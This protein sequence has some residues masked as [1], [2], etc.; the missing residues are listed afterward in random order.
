[1]KNLCHKIL[2]IEDDAADAGLICDM[3]E[4]KEAECV[5]ATTAR[6]SSAIEMLRKNPFEVVLLDL[7]LPD[8]RGIETLRRLLEE[9]PPLPIVVLTVTAD[10][11]LAAE[12]MSMGAQD[13]LVKGRFDADQLYR[14][15]IY[16]MERSGYEQR[17]RESEEK[18]R[19][20]VENANSVVIQTDRKGTV[21]FF[22]EYGR[23]L[24]GYS[25]DEI[26]GR[27][28]RMLIPQTETGSGRDLEEMIG[29]ILNNPDGFIENVNE[30]VRKDG[31]RIWVSWRNR[32]VR[33]A[34][35]DV[36]GNLAIGQDVTERRRLEESLDI[37]SRTLE[38]LNTALKVLLEQR[39][40][41]KRGLEEN[42]SLNV[43]ELVLPY[44]E[45]LKKSRLDAG[46]MSNL[47]ILEAN[48]HEI[49]SPI[50]KTLQRFDLTPREVEVISYLKDGKTTKQIADLMGVSPRAVEF[51]RYNIRK[52]L[53]LD[54]MKT[55]LRTYLRSMV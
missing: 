33:D 1:M 48:L 9:G 19:E 37:K 22:N 52:K 26:I 2:L 40:G 7:A 46:Q 43:K 42:I 15:M 23:T 28:V 55:N 51:H 21:T 20:L 24:F 47:S 39:E 6:L 49:T 18:Y 3:V 44:L 14:A 8:S 36:I 41:D 17:L 4:S 35:G 27:D 45:K 31:Q 25:R 54:Q 30:N 50:L 16:A 12:A 32:A 13:Y 5:V 34:K 11:E 29:N 38:E 10:E 53:G